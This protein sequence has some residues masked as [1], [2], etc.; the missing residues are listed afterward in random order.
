MKDKS[1]KFELPD[2]KTCKTFNWIQSV[3]KVTLGVG[4]VSCIY[5]KS[6]SSDVLR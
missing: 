2:S 4:L 5:R 3:E 6:K 1:W